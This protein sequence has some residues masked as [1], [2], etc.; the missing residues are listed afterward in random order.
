MT[1]FEC[2]YPRAR[3]VLCASLEGMVDRLP[4][5][6]KDRFET[7]FAGPMTRLAKVSDWRLL[8]LDKLVDLHDLCARTP[9][10]QQEADHA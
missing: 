10:A 2:H 3:E 8:P 9:P 6:T 1:F 7:V 5:A 4:E